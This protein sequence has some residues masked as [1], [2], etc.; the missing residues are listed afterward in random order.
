MRKEFEAAERQ[1]KIEMQRKLELEMRAQHAKEKQE[2]IDRAMQERETK[3]KKNED[4]LVEKM[5]EADVRLGKK[6]KEQK[7]ERQ[8]QARLREE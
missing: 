1:N 8:E 3:C 5:K 6:A 7:V 4:Y 2:K